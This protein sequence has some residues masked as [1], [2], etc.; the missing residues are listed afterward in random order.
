MNVNLNWY[1]KNNRNGSV[2]NLVLKSIWVSVSLQ[3]VGAGHLT[4]KKSLGEG[5]FDEKKGPHSGE[6][7]QKK[8]VK[9]PGVSP[10][11]AWAPL[12]LTHTLIVHVDVTMFLKSNIHGKKSCHV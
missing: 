2:E 9:C 4:P 11:G 3:P 8:N 7:D 1:T 10:G 5:A 12:E 6:F